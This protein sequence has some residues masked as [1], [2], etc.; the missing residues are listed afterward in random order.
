MNVSTLETRAVLSHAHSELKSREDLRQLA[1]PPATATFRPVPHYESVTAL[2]ETLLKRKLQV[3]R[4]E[5]AVQ[6]QGHRLFSVLDL[7]SDRGEYGFAIG[8]RTG[9]DRSLSLQL[10]CGLR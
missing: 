9:N 4:E 7:V 2:V 10:I 1:C 6:R 3:R 5:Y 8:L